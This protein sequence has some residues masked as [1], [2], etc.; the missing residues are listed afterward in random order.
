[1]LSAKHS[2]AEAKEC[3][4]EK[5]KIYQKNR[6]CL[7][8][9]NK[10]FF[11]LFFWWFCFFYVLFCLEKPK[12]RYFLQFWSFFVFVSPKGLS[13]LSF[14]SS[15]SVFFFLVFLLSSPFKTPLFF[16]AFCPSTPFWKTLI[17]LISLFFLASSLM[18]A[19]F[20]QTSFPNIPLLKP[21]LFS[22]WLF[23]YFFCSF[24][25]H[26]SCFCLSVLMLVLFLVCFILFCFVFVLFLVLLLHTMKN[27]VFHA[28]RVFSSCWLQVVLYFQFSSMCLFLCD[29]LVLFVSILDIIL[30]LRC[31]F[32]S[33]KKQD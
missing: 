10:V 21:E 29:F 32:V 8:T 27:I 25:F 17:C 31:L 26:V 16:L 20:F 1:M 30:C 11:C 12:R 15:Y 9:C 14:F 24:C 13:L 23:I 22:F 7:P 6:G 3:N 4:F 19:C 33:F 2:S 5:T 18:F 28:I